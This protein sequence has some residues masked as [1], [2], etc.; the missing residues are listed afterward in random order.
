MKD[1]YLW[2][3]TGDADP[4]I[5]HLERVLG[6]LRSKNNSEAAMRAFDNLQRTR[7]RPLRKAFLIAASL[8]FALL[9]LGAFAVIQRQTK[10]QAASDN[11]IAMVSPIPSAT[12]DTQD[13]TAP[14]VTDEIKQESAR[15]QS[16]EVSITQPRRPA[17]SVQKRR[18]MKGSL[19]NGNSQLMAEGLMAK[20]QLI[21]ALQITSSKLNVVQKKVQ[22]AA[23]LGPSS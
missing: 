2:D 22:G 20:E 5:E 6:Q 18:A 23:P 16:Y 13:E 3:K 1:D 8:A 19:V 15:P 11:S 17:T 4:E 10:R 12:T 14:K 9:A 7:P 21:K